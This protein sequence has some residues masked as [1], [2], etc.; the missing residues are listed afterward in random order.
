MHSRRDVLRALSYL[1]AATCA[2]SIV[3][4][5]AQNAQLTFA[6]VT[7]VWWNP[8]P[9]I[10]GANNFYDAHHIGIK[11]SEYATGRECL[12]AVI[13]GNADLGVAAGSPLLFAA[14]AGRTSVVKVVACIS[15]SNDLIHII[16][17]REQGASLPT[18]P[19]GYVKNTASEYALRRVFNG[20]PAAQ[21]AVN[22]APNQLAPLFANGALQSFICWEPYPAIALKTAQDQGIPAFVWSQ[23]GLY[24][25]S[26]F[27]FARRDRMADQATSI[28][29][30]LD[31]LQDAATW[32]AENR[33]RS[34]EAIS[35]NMG[36]EQS[37]F[38]RYWTSVD[39]QV[40]RSPDAI[41]S[42]L[43][44]EASTAFETGV[45]STHVDLAALAK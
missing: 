25:L 35:R 34:Q 32:L 3:A 42:L 20:M 45:T 8:D 37:L 41:A 9:A 33:Q 10:A 21:D 15:Q 11:R 39:F 16:S 44:V 5:G 4:C 12:D 1:S 38:E 24:N 30:F 43:A 6:D 23:S 27:V 19:V 40:R 22:V 13:A 36:I 26:F 29:S 14:L 2:N 28:N 7:R 31:A 18:G 17:H